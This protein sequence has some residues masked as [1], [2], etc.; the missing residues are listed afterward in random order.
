MPTD[1]HECDILRIVVAIS[2]VAIACD[3]ANALAIRGGLAAR[4]RAARNERTTAAG[5]EHNIPKRP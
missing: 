5:S 4:G 2:E 1:P 3:G